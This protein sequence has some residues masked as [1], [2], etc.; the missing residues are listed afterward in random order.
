MK[1]KP[2]SSLNHFTVPVAMSGVPPVSSCAAIA[3][4]ADPDLRALA[5]L[6]RAPARTLRRARDQQSPCVWQ[7]FQPF[8]ASR[9]GATVEAQAVQPR[10]ERQPVEESPDT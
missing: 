9:F 2:F 5:R 7:S 10:R 8:S 6:H 3:E 4:E 1:P